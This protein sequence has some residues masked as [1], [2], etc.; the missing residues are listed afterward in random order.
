MRGGNKRADGMGSTVRPEQRV[1][2]DHPLRPIRAI[3]T[4]VVKERSQQFSKLDSRWGRPSIPPEKLLRAL[5][6]QAFYTIRSE[7]RLMEQLDYNLLFR[8]FVGP[9]MDDPVWNP[10]TFT[11]NRE[12]LLNGEVAWRFFQA[13]V[14]Q[15]RSRGLLS[16]DHFTV[17]GTLI[18]AW[19]SHESFVPKDGKDPKPGDGSRNAAVRGTT[20]RASPRAA[21]SWDHTPSW[22]VKRELLDDRRAHGAPSR[23]RGQSEEEEARRANLRLDEDGGRPAEN[24]TPRTRQGR[25]D[26]RLRSGR[27]QPD[28]DPKPDLQTGVMCSR[29]VPSLLNGP[30][31]PPIED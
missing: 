31:R 26:V 18:E 21:A 19:A 17:D 8:W 7:R 4:E 14:A 24:E 20:C 22:G 6:L 3:A 10:T 30:S 29:H 13:V 27:L 2:E 9:S 5:L 16:E 1:P 12:R 25:L 15:A 11:K 23:L 28:P